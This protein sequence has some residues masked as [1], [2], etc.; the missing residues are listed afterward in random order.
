MLIFSYSKNILIFIHLLTVFSSNTNILIFNSDPYAYGHSALTKDGDI[1]IE[2][3]Y[4]NKRLFYGLNKNGR[5]Y[6]QENN[7]SVP[8]KYITING[9]NTNRV[10]SRNIF[11][12]LIQHIKFVNST[13]FYRK[14]NI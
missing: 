4:E 5:G 12:Q 13:I 14:L 3:S 10:Q 1:I 8:T 6:F 11:V 2:Y 7:L 9:D